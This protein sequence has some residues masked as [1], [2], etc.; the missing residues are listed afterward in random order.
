MVNAYAITFA[1]FLMLG[2]RAADHFGQ[3][4]VFVV[5]LVVFAFA[6]LAG[7]LAPDKDTLIVA[8][9]IPGLRRRADGRVSLA[10]I[11]SS[12]PRGPRGT[13]PSACGER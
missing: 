10:I 11:T 6:S 12:F 1:G 13:A 4:T 8:R 5:A 7:G 9:A 2:G 3:R